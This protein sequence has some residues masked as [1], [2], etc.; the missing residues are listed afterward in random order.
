MLVNFYRIVCFLFC[1]QLVKPIAGQ[2]VVQDFNQSWKFQLAD[3][4]S[5]GKWRKV[6]LPHDW[7]IELPFTEKAAATTL[8]GALPG[9]IGWYQKSFQLPITSKG[10][11]FYIEFDG[12][13]RNAEVWINGHALGKRPNGYISFQY[14]LTDHL[15]FGDKPNQVLVKADNSAQPNSRWYT[16]SGIY[17]NVRLVSTG[18]IA[19]GYEGSFVTTPKVDKEMAIVQLALTVNSQEQLTEKLTVFS[20][21]F[22]QANIPVAQQATEVNIQNGSNQLKQSFQVKQP[23]L[24]STEHPNLYHIQTSIYKGNLLM[25]DYTTV[26]GIRDFHFDAAKGFF[27]NGKSLKIKGV[28]M[29]HDLGALGAAMNV[30]ALKR[31]LRILQE[32]G[33]NAIRTAHNPPARELL[34]L[35]DQ[36]GFLVMDEAFDMWNKKKNKFD[37][38]S[39]FPKWHKRDLEDQIKRDRNHPSIILW[40][41]GNEIREQFDSSGIRIAKELVGIVKN[42]DS[43]RPVTCALTEPD[44]KKNFIYQSGALDVLGFNYHIEAYE[45]FPQKY[46]GQKFIGAE[47]VSGLA[48]R[49]HYDQPSDSL[50]FWPESSKFK[51]VEKGNPDYSVSAYD[52]VAAYWGSTHEATW[53]LIKKY[54]FLSGLFV[55]SGFDYLGEPTPYPWPARSAYFGIVDLAGFPKDVYYM[56]QSEWTNKPMLH[57][58]PHWNWEKGKTVDVWTYYNQAD[59]VELFLNG[60]SLGIKRKQMDD[61][62]LMWRIPFEPGTLKAISRK[63]GQ[64]VQVKE[65]KTAGA[66]YRLEVK[67]DRKIIHADGKDLSYLT[68]RVLDRNGQLVPQSDNLIKVSVKGMGSLKAMDNGFQA[69]IKS[70]QANPYPAYKGL[71]LAII[72]SGQKA[73]VM[74]VKIS[75]PG[76]LSSSIQIIS[77]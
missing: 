53:K 21:L 19:V 13:Y 31:Q 72:Q 17:R 35:C 38:Y 70:F 20:V 63:N 49:G 59:E 12:I 27:L 41:I 50:R 54:P 6:N 40:S 77:R 45:D 66:A 4:I 47:N 15:F 3:T 57:L 24:W 1:L 58:F 62:H 67:A 65:I 22:D 71:C 75:S 42:L 74:E 2:R 7:S 43:T 61:L 64:I 23:A 32:M 52:H 5:T 11:R 44:P 9:G 33:A 30:A 76:L 55:W 46:P 16:G 14:E 10:K 48:S 28:C 34:D 73:G 56:Y 18:N 69:S 51:T 36:M 68:I 39:D 8:G 29:H 37:Y 25:D 60:K 26:L